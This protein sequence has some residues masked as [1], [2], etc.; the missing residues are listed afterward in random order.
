MS[1]AFTPEGWRRLLPAWITL[2]LCVAVSVGGVFGAQW[3]LDRQRRENSNY[4]RRVRDARSHLDS[5]R[6]ERESLDQSVDV[7]RTLVDRGVLKGERRLEL[8]ERLD[9]LRGRYH[10]YGMDYDIGIQRPLV[11]PGGRAFN[12]IDILSSRVTLKVRALHEGDVVGFL[13]ELGQSRHGFFPMERC[14][15]QRIEAPVAESLAAHVEAECAFEWITLKDKTNG[16]G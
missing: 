6:R 3:F 14:R 8:V 7:F 4:E 9:A 11:L 12:A 2:A 5:V 1:V 16:R 10:L 13:D 15:M